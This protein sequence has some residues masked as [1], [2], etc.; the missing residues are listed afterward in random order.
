MKPLGFKNY[1]SIGHLPCS[2]MGPGDHSVHEGQARIC[3]EKARDK[4]DR[5]FVTEKSGRL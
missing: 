5:I 4:H 2:R 3:L 1:G